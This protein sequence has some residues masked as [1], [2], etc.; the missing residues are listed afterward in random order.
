MN[1]ATKNKVLDAADKAAE[2]TLLAW[3][4][5][6]VAIRGALP[7]VG[8]GMFDVPGMV[9]G[10]RSVTCSATGYTVAS[11][12]SYDSAQSALARCD[13]LSRSAR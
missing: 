3:M 12:S 1:S 2:S 7:S 10:S 8:I 5:N 13:R 11:F 4:A 6:Y 9:V